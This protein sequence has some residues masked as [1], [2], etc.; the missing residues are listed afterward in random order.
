MLKHLAEAHPGSVSMLSQQ[1]RMNHEICNLSNEIVYEGALKCAD[2][3][4]ANRRLDLPGFPDNMNE[5]DRFSWLSVSVDP[6]YPV[7]FLDTDSRSSQLATESFVSLERTTGRSGSGS[8]VNDT[9]AGLVRKVVTSL[10]SCGLAASSIGVICPFRAQVSSVL[11][12]RHVHDTNGL[13]STS[14][15]SYASSMSTLM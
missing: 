3:E 6:Q 4:V 12:F 15:S 5:P 1:Y 7:V 8:I 11:G 2:A 13:R 14:E 9:E 10:I